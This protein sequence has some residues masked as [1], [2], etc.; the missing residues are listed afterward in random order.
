MLAKDIDSE[1]RIERASSEAT[2]EID[3]ALGTIGK[4]GISSLVS[5]DP[6]KRR[7]TWKIRMQMSREE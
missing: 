6:K 5:K 3:S 1:S 2:S 7:F 4:D